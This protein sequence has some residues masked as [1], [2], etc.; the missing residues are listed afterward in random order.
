MGMVR[1]MS[2]EIKQSKCLE[3]ISAIAYKGKGNLHSSGRY[4]KALRQTQNLLEDENERKSYEYKIQRC[5]Q[6]HIVFLQESIINS[7]G[8][9][10]NKNID[11]EC[12]N[13]IKEL[14]LSKYC[15]R[16]GNLSLVDIECVRQEK[17][18]SRAVILNKNLVLPCKVKSTD[19][20]YRFNTEI[21]MTK[22]NVLGYACSEYEGVDTR[23]YNQAKIVKLG[24][25]IKNS[26]LNKKEKTVTR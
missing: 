14:M 15:I 7:Y 19:G 18:L 11:K 22:D 17:A 1:T 10:V 5:L 26:E 4:I 8:K 3:D 6:K 2:K 13:R 23:K 21:I 12:G 20:N 25:G 16:E 9:S 24:E